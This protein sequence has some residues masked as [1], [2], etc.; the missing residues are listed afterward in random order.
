MQN[1]LLKYVLPGD[2]D[3]AVTHLSWNSRV[4]NLGAGDAFVPTKLYIHTRLRR[5]GR[6]VLGARFL[7]PVA[8][9]RVPAPELVVAPEHVVGPTVQDGGHVHGVL[10]R[11]GICDAVP[12]LDGVAVDESH[13]EGAGYPRDLGAER[14]E[15]G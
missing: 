10:V 11:R 1:V 3:G 5:Y 12:G 9:S 7:S 15:T 8:D 13:G 4:S 6:N 2:P 14:C